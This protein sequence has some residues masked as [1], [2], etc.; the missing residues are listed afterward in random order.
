MAFAQSILFIV[1]ASTFV[2]LAL[3]ALAMLGLA[4]LESSIGILRDGLAVDSV[5]PSWESLDLVGGRTGSPSGERCQ[6]LLFADHSL[7]EF[8]EVVRAVHELHAA[9]PDL[10]ILLLARRDAEVLALTVQL[11]G[12]GAL[13]TAVPNSDE[14]YRA[15]NVRVMPY[16]QFVAADGRLLAGGLVNRGEQLSHLWSIARSRIGEGSLERRDGAK[17]AVLWA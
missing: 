13:V 9:T 17:E 2:A 1:V 12:F 14:V 8:P 11:L 3:L 16:A 5:A 6:L 4:R 15:F 10:E 7:A